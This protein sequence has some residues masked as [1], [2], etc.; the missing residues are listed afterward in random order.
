VK[1]DLSLTEEKFHQLLA[2]LDA[3]PS[4]AGEKY[5]EIRRRLITIFLNR[6]CE[7]AEDLAD[8]TINRVAQRVGELKDS[9]VGDP[10]RYFY[11]VSKKIFLE[12]RRKRSRPLPAPPPVASRRELEP[13]M[14]CL[15]ECLEKLEPANRELIL[16]YYQEQKQ[17]KIS[18]HKEMGERLRLKAGALRARTHRIRVKLEKCVLEC[19]ERTA[20]SNDI[21]LLII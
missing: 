19:L 2:W 5:E 6:Q 1:I 10:A 21:G 20:E 17:A 3:D 4:R 8:E 14:A 12:Y 9:Y 18:S 16:R 13:Y 11:G 7:E 15:D